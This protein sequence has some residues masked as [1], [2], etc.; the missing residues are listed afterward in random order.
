MIC[1]IDDV[2]VSK[3]DEE[4]NHEGEEKDGG[5]PNGLSPDHLLLIFDFLFCHY[6][7]KVF[8]VVHMDRVIL[9]GLN[10]E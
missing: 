8:F 6:L 7:D 3:A 1:G 5:L 2:E 10:Q 9:L 4:V